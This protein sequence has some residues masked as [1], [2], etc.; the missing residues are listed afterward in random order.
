MPLR[1]SAVAKGMPRLGVWHQRAEAHTNHHR[2]SHGGALVGVD[3]WVFQG[4]SLENSGKFWL[5]TTNELKIGQ[6][7]TMTLEC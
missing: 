7:S 2:D 1:L 3:G 6:R 4:K 5:F